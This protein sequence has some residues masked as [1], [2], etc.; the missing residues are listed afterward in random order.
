MDLLQID[1]KVDIPFNG[2]ASIWQWSG[3]TL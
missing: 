2:F 3:Y 1:S